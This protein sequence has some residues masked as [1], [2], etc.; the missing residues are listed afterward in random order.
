MYRR[1]ITLVAGLALLTT[2][3]GCGNNTDTTTPGGGNASIAPGTSA[4]LPAGSTMAKI[5]DKGKLVVGTKF[6]Q[7]LFGNKG[8]SGDPEGFDVEI[9]KV[10]ARAIFGPDID[11]KVEFIETPTRIREDSIEQGKVDL[12]V[13]TYTINDARKQKVGFAGP[14][15]VAGQDLLVK[16]DNTSITGV[17]SLAGKKVCSAQGSTP[18]QNLQAKAPQADVSISFDVYTKCLEA[19]KD[20]RVEAVSTD[21][22]ILLGYVAQDEDLKVVGKKFSNEPYGIGVKKE[23]NDFRAFINDTLQKAYDDGTWASLFKAQVGDKTKVATPAPP[24]IDRY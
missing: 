16:K 15:Y 21:D 20:G 14:Y 6:D 12:I 18:L 11:G 19:L 9:A 2:A 8:L 24:K 23:A 4:A 1:L 17:E 10:I 7:P 3:A 22:V 13:A 5:K